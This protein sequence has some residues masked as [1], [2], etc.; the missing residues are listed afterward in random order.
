MV[1][2]LKVPT[3]GGSFKETTIISI[4]C[5]QGCGNLCLPVTIIVTRLSLLL[6]INN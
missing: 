4:Y 2:E 5:Q 3:T 6:N 1:I